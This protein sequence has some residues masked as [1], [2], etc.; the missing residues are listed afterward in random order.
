MLKWK[1]KYYKQLY[2]KRLMDKFL[3]RHR[4]PKLTQEK[5]DNLSST[6]SIRVT[7]IKVRNLEQSVFQAQMASLVKS[8]NISGRNN[9]SSTQNSSKN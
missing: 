2:A 1:R 8:I 5:I 3:L 7:E 6:V 4:L 9:T